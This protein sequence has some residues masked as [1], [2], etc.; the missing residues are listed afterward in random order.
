MNTDYRFSVNGEPF[1]TFQCAKSYAQ[2][3]ADREQ[4]TV[5]LRAYQ[6]NGE[7]AFDHHLHP[8]VCAGAIAF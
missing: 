6:R 3:M 7:P 8:S 2:A 1:H 4:K 5:T